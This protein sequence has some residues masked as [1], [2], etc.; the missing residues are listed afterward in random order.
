MNPSCIAGV[1]GYPTPARSENTAPSR[2][3]AIW[4]T[5]TGS[6]RSVSSSAND[7]V[8]PDNQRYSATPST[9]LKVRDVKGTS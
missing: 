2:F 3:G 7:T 4:R 8:L 9:D 1:N 5:I 6:F